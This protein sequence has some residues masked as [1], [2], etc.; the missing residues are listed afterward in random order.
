M[1][2]PMLQNVQK[3]V[4]KTFNGSLPRPPYSPD[5]WVTTYFDQCNTEFQNN[6]FIFTKK[7]NFGLKK[8]SYFGTEAI[9]RQKDGKSHS[10]R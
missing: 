4:C 5:F 3:T 10:Q 8:Q 9:L 2:N 1:L 6:I 7:W